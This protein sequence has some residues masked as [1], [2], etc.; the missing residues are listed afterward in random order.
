[1][2]HRRTLQDIN[3]VLQEVF[4]GG[5]QAESDR[6]E[7]TD[8][9]IADQLLW[10]HSPIWEISDGKRRHKSGRRSPPPTT[11]TQPG[12]GAFTMSI[13]MGRRPPLASR[14]RRLLLS[15]LRG[16]PPRSPPALQA[17]PKVRERVPEARLVKAALLGLGITLDR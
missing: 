2:R 1:M 5:R 14:C 8:Y 15:T 10:P 4:L 7:A 6:L 17:Y 13:L 11:H 3:L 12:C 9:S 16:H